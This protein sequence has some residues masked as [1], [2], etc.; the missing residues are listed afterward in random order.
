MRTFRFSI[1]C[2]LVCAIGIGGSACT[3]MKTIRPATDPRMPA[4]SAVK[5]GDEVTLHMGD[6]RR[7]KIRVSA[8]DDDGIVSMEGIRYERRDITHLQ[9]RSFSV[10][11]T[12]GLV[13]GVAL[14]AL[15]VAGMMIASALGSIMGGG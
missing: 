10:A 6:G 13:A 4:F 8:V 15:V 12:T 5:A 3:S 1:S 2:L 11:K 7:L 14:G 9:R